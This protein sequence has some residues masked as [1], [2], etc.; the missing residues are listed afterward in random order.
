MVITISLIPSS[1]LQHKKC[2]LF[3]YKE[4][5]KQRVS[6]YGF[7]VLRELIYQGSRLYPADKFIFNPLKYSTM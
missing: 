2:C 4:V 3:H 5:A 1:A 7:T 6:E